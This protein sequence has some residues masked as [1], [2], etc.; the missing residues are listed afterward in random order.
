MGT[1]MIRL[2]VLA[3]D[4]WP[5]WRELRLAALREAPGA[6]GAKLADW[7]HEDEPRWRQ[8]L[9]DVPFNALAEIGDTPV[10]MVSG[11]ALD[12]ERTVELI[13]M[14]VA[15]AARGRGVGD[16]LIAAVARWAEDQ[17]ARR[18]VLRVFDHNRHA[19]SLYRRN[20]FVHTEGLRMAR[21]LG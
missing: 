4:D 12:T 10:G 14:W 1:R 6:F 16:A 20:G 19:E 9:I 17:S 7:V 15:P 5:A 21:E 11:T 13:S 3:A 2:R 8:R 18:I